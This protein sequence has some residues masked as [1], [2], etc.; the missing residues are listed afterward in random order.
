MNNEDFTVVPVGGLYS[1]VS[2]IHESGHA[3]VANHYGQR[4]IKIDITTPTPTCRHTTTGSDD[5][6][7]AVMSLGGVSA[8]V[9]WEWPR[10]TGIWKE[11]RE[12]LARK[13]L[14]ANSY[15]YD[16]YQRAF[17]PD[18]PE[19]FD[20]HA[21]KALEILTGNWAKVQIIASHLRTAG[22]VASH[23]EFL[24]LLGES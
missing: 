8:Q 7:I 17:S 9:I 5:G 21:L 22:K 11:T 3:I 20:P 13:R 6:E 23:E 14:A 18:N 15:D 12:R 10:L 1:E 4:I 24:S 16:V 19:T 2:A